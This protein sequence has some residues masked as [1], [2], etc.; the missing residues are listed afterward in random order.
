MALA[1]TCPSL[2]LWPANRTLRTGAL[3]PACWAF[4]LS[5]LGSVVILLLAPPSC[6]VLLGMN[7]LGSKLHSVRS[8]AEGTGCINSLLLA[9]VPV[10]PDA[11]PLEGLLACA[12]LDS[13]PPCD[14]CW[15]SSLL[16][17]AFVWTSCLGS[18][19]RNC[20]LSCSS[21]G[22]CPLSCCCCN[23]L[24]AC[25]PD[26]PAMRG[27][28]LASIGDLLCNFGTVMLWLAC[29]SPPY[30]GC[31][32]M[33]NTLSKAGP[34]CQV[35]LLALSCHWHNFHL[36]SCSSQQALQLQT[37]LTSQSQADVP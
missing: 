20:L 14:C 4:S 24:V 34:C 13:L 32:H 8:V 9:L 33:L 35:C 25:S 2:L 11:N 7:L 29:C 17:C 21:D 15:G 26:G 18:C 10:G 16:A 3:W 22:N 31:S 6:S 30:R 5:R 1:D 12:S 19:C 36:S 37:S 28:S 27:F 23:S